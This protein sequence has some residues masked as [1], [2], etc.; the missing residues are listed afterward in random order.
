MIT[1][2]LASVSAT[3]AASARDLLVVK[4]DRAKLI[5]YPA[6]TDAVIVG[7]PL[8]ADV[9]MLKSTGMLVVTGKGFGETNLIL[10]DHDGEVLTNTTLRVQT[11]DATLTVQRGSARQTYACNPRCEPTVSIGD[12]TGYFNEAV[13]EIKTRNEAAA[14]GASPGAIAGSTPV[15]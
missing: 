6:E 7:N 11:T 1:A 13:G 12:E 14:S 15:H 3:G 4:M 8:I 2:A 10:L 5:K 9:A